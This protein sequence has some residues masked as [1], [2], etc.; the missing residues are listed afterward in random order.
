MEFGRNT[1]SKG[2]DSIAST[3][4]GSKSSIKPRGYF[5]DQFEVRHPCPIFIAQLIWV[6]WVMQN[7]SNF[8]AHFEGTGPEIWRQTNGQ[9]DAFVSGA[10]AKFGVPA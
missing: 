10:G 5:A 2:D 6:S 8:N 9:I 4:S 7:R 1:I 3:P